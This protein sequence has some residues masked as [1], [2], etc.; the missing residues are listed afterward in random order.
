MPELKDTLM[1]L[2][3]QLGLEDIAMVMMDYGESKAKALEVIGQI[4]L[5]Q[6]WLYAAES[7]QLATENISWAEFEERQG[8]EQQGDDK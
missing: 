6:K 7:M 5:A 1:E 2:V 3:A 8:F 4:E